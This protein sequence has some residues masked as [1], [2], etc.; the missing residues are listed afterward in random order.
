MPCVRCIFARIYVRVS[1]NVMWACNER[2]TML[3]VR[4]R[5]FVKSI[6]P[7]TPKFEGE[8]DW[9]LKTLGCDAEHVTSKKS[10]APAD[11]LL[12][13]SLSDKFD[14]IVALIHIIAT[15][16]QRPLIQTGPR[17]MLKRHLCNRHTPVPQKR[18]TTA[19]W[20]HSPHVDCHM[21]ALLYD[22]L[23]GSCNDMLLK[24]EKQIILMTDYT[25]NTQSQKL[26]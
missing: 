10:T 26:I 9:S 6:A 22:A 16:I 7:T 5:L 13:P 8:F 18:D 23:D 17:Q 4:Q 11:K 3:W 20:R 15:V 25:W 19:G 24:I 21:L 12:G 1:A 14:I 2:I